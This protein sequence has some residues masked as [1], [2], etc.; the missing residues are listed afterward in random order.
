MRSNSWGFL[1]RVVWGSEGGEGGLAG[2][3]GGGRA[4]GGLLN[5]IPG[6]AW[7]PTADDTVLSI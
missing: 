5:T 2:V 1:V 7:V 4:R 3:V 6:L